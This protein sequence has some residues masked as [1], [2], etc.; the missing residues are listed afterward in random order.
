[1]LINKYHHLKQTL[2]HP[3]LGTDLANFE[4]TQKLI[5]VFHPTT[6]FNLVYNMQH[7]CSGQNRGKAPNKSRI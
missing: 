6:V 2:G 1:M 5:F 4:N 7:C 3:D